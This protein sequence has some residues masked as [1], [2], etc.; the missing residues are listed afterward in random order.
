MRFIVVPLKA[1]KDPAHYN[2][3]VCLYTGCKNRIIK[4]AAGIKA[5]IQTAIDIQAGDAVSCR[6]VESGKAPA[7][8]NLTIC[9][10]TG[11]KNRIIKT[12]AG[13]KARIQTAIGIQAGDAVSCCAVESGKGP[14]HYNLTVCLYT[15]CTN[16]IIKTAAGIKARI[17]TAI[18][19]QTG[20]ASLLPCRCNW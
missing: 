3:T 19:I 5:R 4:T 18:G 16:T 15:G 6:A 13:I 14:A 11:C 10:Y 7:Y 9:L 17:Q 20:D 1:V 8:Y 2:L 12:A